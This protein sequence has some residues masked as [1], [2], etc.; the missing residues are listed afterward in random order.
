MSISCMS[1]CFP[2]PAGYSLPIPV[3]PGPL[4]GETLS[5]QQPPDYPPPNLYS[6]PTSP[7][8]GKTFG[9]KTE[10]SVREKGPSPNI[11]NL[12]QPRVKSAH[13]TH[14][15]FSWKCK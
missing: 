14:R 13:F 6:L 7:Q 4:I 12:R 10:L 9:L 5:P 8:E 2:G 15:A 3:V 11:Y 1:T